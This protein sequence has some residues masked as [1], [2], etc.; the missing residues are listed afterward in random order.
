M[1]RYLSVMAIL[2]LGKV[3]EKKF[4]NPMLNFVIVYL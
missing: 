1:S 4:S 3:I 2:V